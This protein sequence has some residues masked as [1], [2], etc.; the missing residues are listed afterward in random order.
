MSLR[1]ARKLADEQGLKARVLDLRWLNPLNHDWVAEHAKAT[2]KLLVV[3]ECRRAGGLG[4]ALIA[5][6]TERAGDAVSSL[7]LA[8]DDT[9]VPL[10][11]A[12]TVV[13]PTE[14]SIHAAACQLAGG[15]QRKRDNTVQ[16]RS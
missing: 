3:D 7:L 8:A 1:A 5:G 10:G 14:D 11:P 9:Y 12:M 6:L 15:K 13:M 16:R 2:G 4:E